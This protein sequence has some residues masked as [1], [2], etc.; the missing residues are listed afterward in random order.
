[1]RSGTFDVSAGTIGSGNTA[2]TTGG[3]V[4]VYGG[5]FNLK[6]NPSCSIQGNA[7]GDGGGV[8]VQTNGS[9]NLS[10]WGSITANT[11]SGNGGGVYVN[12][13]S[14]SLTGSAFS[15]TVSGNSA[16]GVDGNV[17]LPEGKKI[18]VASDMNNNARVGVSMEKPGTFTDGYKAS[19]DGK[20]P[21]TY[22]TSDDTTYSIALDRN[23]EALLGKTH[24]VTVEKI[25]LVGVTADKTTAFTGETVTLTVTEPEGIPFVLKE[26]TVT[27]TEGGSTKALTPVK[28]EDGQYTFEMP[29]ADVTV[30]GESARQY[31]VV[32]KTLSGG[33]LT[34]DKEFAIEGETV[35]LTVT[36]DA[37]YKIENVTYAPNET[38]TAIAIEPVDGVYSFTMP[39]DAVYVNAEFLTPWM[40]LQKQINETENGGTVKLDGDVRATAVDTALVVPEGK[41]VTIDLNRFRINRQLESAVENGNV[42]TVNGNLTVKDTTN[43]QAGVILGGYNGGYGGG[44][45]VGSSGNFTLAGGTI[46][47][48]TA[49]LG[50]GVYVHEGGTVTL[51][52]G[53]IT[54]NTG[55]NGIGGVWFA[56]GTFNVSG[57]PSIQGNT[58]LGQESAQE[59]NVY[60][61]GSGGNARIN[62]TGK[63]DA[64][65]RIGVTGALGVFTSGLKDRGTADNFTCDDDDFAVGIDDDGEAYIDRGITVTFDADGGSAVE[66]K[67]IVSGTIPIRPDDPA[68]PGFAL[69]E[70]QLDGSAYNFDTP[71]YGNTTL[72]AKWLTH[73]NIAAGDKV[74]PEPV[75]I[76]GLGYTVTGNI[77]A[78]DEE[79]L[80]ISLNLGEP[81]GTNPKVYPIKVSYEP[82]DNFYITTVD[83]KYT[84]A[85][86]SGGSGSSGGSDGSGGQTPGDSPINFAVYGYSGEYDGF[87]HGIEIEREGSSEGY[88]ILFADKEFDSWDDVWKYTTNL[89]RPSYGYTDVGTHKVYYYVLDG[90][91]LISGSKEVTITKADCTVTVPETHALTNNGKEQQLV[92]AVDVVG[93]TAKYALGNDDKVV[94]DESA[95]TADIPAGTETGTYFVWYK[96]EGDGNHNDTEP[97]CIV[98]T[99]SDDEAVEQVVD[100]I[101]AL[102][103]VGKVASS[104]KA[105]IKAAR[106]AFDA[107]TAEQKAMVPADTL[108]KL[109]SDEAAIVEVQKKAVKKVTI[110]TKVVSAKAV[111]AAVA[112]AG[113]DSKYVTTFVLGKKV[114]KIGKG[115]FKNY[116]NVKKLLVK[117]KKLKKAKVK[118][119]LKGSKVAKVKVMIG[120]KKANR[121]YVKLYKKVFAKKVVGK[122]VQVS[123]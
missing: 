33:T 47:D 57:N 15:A 85:S 7:A 67:K 3:G 24:N 78:A 117:T 96:V 97:A 100:M 12:G 90:A 23:G 13:G 55:L 122:K 50:G 116:K 8:A 42:I 6:G 11:A 71:L 118:E 111:K 35:T 14:F 74:G 54:G 75:D 107:L 114:S 106:Q 51:T 99:I 62:V 48:N 27:Y 44:V 46:S 88:E 17:Y 119:S 31:P 29:D 102:P 80:E 66:A 82:N 63:M 28:G 49:V 4:A 10:N 121:K 89:G 79:A 101:N 21:A 39:K 20:D 52:G 38:D 84:V 108:K 64:S 105:A 123:L 76:S 18:T 113:G 34:A 110:N 69:K 94:P 60:V 32:V 98:V 59:Y 61:V 26:L 5:T 25:S 43:T 72:K 45:V 70:W 41:S 22:F 53:S 109:T 95:Y 120:S 37:G 91:T 92:E 40:K 103:A 77:S 2:S 81:T 93:G 9:F 36:P 104:D 86:G 68:K 19:M 83:G 16:A 112:K 73:V 56:G 87:E 30:R 65:A 58:S 115:A 1:M